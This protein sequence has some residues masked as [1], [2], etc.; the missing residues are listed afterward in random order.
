MIAA[1]ISRMR[2]ANPRAPSDNNQSVNPEQ[3][4][5]CGQ[6]FI[7][8]IDNHSL[9]QSHASKK[10]T[11]VSRSRLLCYNENME[12]KS[13]TASITNRAEIKVTKQAISCSGSF[14][15]IEKV[16]KYKNEFGSDPAKWPLK[17]VHDS[18][19]I[20]INELILK[21]TGQHKI[22]YAQEEIC[23]CRT[24]PTETVIQSIKQ[25]CHTVKEISRATKAGTGCGTCVPQ[26]KI[27][28]SEI[29]RK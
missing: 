1:A 24:V 10:G 8:H 9:V 18:S 11:E 14:A 4:K 21:L 5:P 2:D 3:I 25:D 27:L 12:T 7:I 26:L 13:I 15:L 23:H 16:N 17:A 19:D 20:L 6:F 22:S 28:L 29:L